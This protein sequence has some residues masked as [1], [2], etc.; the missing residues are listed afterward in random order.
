MRINESIANKVTIRAA[1]WTKFSKTLLHVK[2]RNIYDIVTYS[3][4]STASGNC[5]HDDQ[6][7]NS[8]GD[9][10]VHGFDVEPVGVSKDYVEESRMRIGR[11]PTDILYETIEV[12][13]LISLAHAIVQICINYNWKIITLFNILQHCTDSHVFNRGFTLNWIFC[14]KL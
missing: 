2:A 9:Y 10:K 1:Y 3:S 7:N 6:C 12:T 14:L 4:M 11:L 13:W 8:K 5:T